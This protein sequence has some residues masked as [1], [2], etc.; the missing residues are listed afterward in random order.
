MKFTDINN[1]PTTIEYYA[2]TVDVNSVYDSL[3][4]IYDKYGI[5]ALTK[6]DDILLGISQRFVY[7]VDTYERENDWRVQLRFHITEFPS[8]MELAF[9]KMCNIFQMWYA[10]NCQATINIFIRKKDSQA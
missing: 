5:D 2:S 1:N 7:H 8:V 9:V 4:E 10:G 3:D 6:F